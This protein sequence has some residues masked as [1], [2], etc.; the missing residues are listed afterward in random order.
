MEISFQSIKF[1]RKFRY[2]LAL[3]GCG[4]N[5]FEQVFLSIFIGVPVLVLINFCELVGL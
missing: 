5:F 1:L 4:N 3:L 2:H